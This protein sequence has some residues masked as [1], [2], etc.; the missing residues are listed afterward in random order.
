VRIQRIHPGLDDKILTA[1]NGMMLA[2]LSEAARVL[3]RADYKIAAIKNADFILANMKSADGRLLR[4][5]KS[6]VTNPR[7]KAILEDYGCLI[8][9]LI[10]LY[11]TTFDERW[12]IEA[13]ALTDVAIKHF[14]AQDGGFFDTADDHEALIARP[15]NMQ[16]NAVPSGNAMMA[17]NLVRLAAYT[18]DATY[19]EAARR[20]L[21]LLTEAMRQYP[22]A[23]GESLSAVDMLVSGLAEIA[24]IGAPDN[25]ATKSLLDVVRKPYRPN[26]ITALASADVPAEATVPLLGYRTLRNDQP[27]VYVCR[28][29][30]CANPVNTPAELEALLAT[31]RP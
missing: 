20:T 29:F 31:A 21:A 5:H 9:G 22:Q 11:Q 26:I 27:T 24:L 12:F 13:R 25:A 19:D 15:R 28:N 2:S 1:W 10:E 4:T 3:D 6:G 18:A 14:A 7:I 30:A 23:F 17:K 8:D 16:D